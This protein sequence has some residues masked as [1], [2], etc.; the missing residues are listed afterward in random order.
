MA[1]LVTGASG[2]IGGN[3]IRALLARGIRPRALVRENRRA[4]DGLDLDL[5]RG[6][7][8]DPESLRRA[9]AGTDVVYHLAGRISVVE[10]DA[11]ET[12]A[13]NVEGTRNVVAVCREVG[14]KRLAHVSSIHALAP[15]PEDRPVNETRPLAEGPHTPQYDRSK[16]AGER[17][18]LAGVGRGLDA[19][20]IN[21][22]AVMGP[23]DY[24]PSAM[25]QVLLDLYHRRIPALVVGGFDWVDVRDVV[26]GA[27]AA[28][29][30]GGRGERYL[31][32]GHRATLRELAV[33]AGEIT[34]RKAPG[35][36]IPMWLAQASVP[37]AAVAASLAGQ[38]PRMTTASLR[39]LRAH[40]DIRHDKATR[41]L[42]YAPR[43]LHDTLADTY[44]WFRAERVL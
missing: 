19:V 33:M 7:V 27:I 14:V 15:E 4:L 16:A 21:P 39:A 40:R 8:L 23:H 34:G 25:G 20:I 35:L 41:E 36:V 43:P 11:A 44:A 18:V 10:T 38:S 13:V 12:W 17:E 30:R 28:A 31:L 26:E 3:L 2:H 1:V 24:R 42:G 6:D 22:T 5:V 29:E 37:L 9:A 32:S